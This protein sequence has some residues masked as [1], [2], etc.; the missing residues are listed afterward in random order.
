MRT[1][2]SLL[3][4]PYSAF[5]K[6]W[7]VHDHQHLLADPVTKRDYLDQLFRFKPRASKAGVRFFAFCLMDNHVHE[8]GA[9][10]EDFKPFSDWMRVAHGT[11]GQRYN[12]RNGRRGKFAIERPKTVVL[13]DDRAILQVMLYLD[14]NPVVAGLVDDAADWEWSSHRFFAYG[15]KNSWTK[16]LDIPD[17]YLSLGETEEERQQQYR[18]LYE[19]YVATRVSSPNSPEKHLKADPRSAVRAKG[20]S[21]SA[22]DQEPKQRSKTNR[23]IPGD[24]GEGDFFGQTE[25]VEE[26]RASISAWKRERVT[27]RRADDPSDEEALLAA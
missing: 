23:W 7:Q 14:A 22:S 19:E 4:Q 10:D 9:I 24:A 17:A 26:R 15:E 18:E 20:A 1:P 25:W 21:E 11:F 6:M 8:C 12:K 3:L 2:R 16:N 13:E 5:H 27:R